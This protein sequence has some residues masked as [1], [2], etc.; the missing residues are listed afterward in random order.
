[1]QHFQTGEKFPSLILFPAGIVRES[2]STNSVGAACPITVAF[3]TAGNF[4]VANS[5]SNNILSTIF[6][7]SISG[8]N[9]IEKYSANFTDLGAFATNLNQPWG[10]AF[11][12]SGNLFV[13][14]SGTNGTYRSSIL[15]IAPDGSITTFANPNASLKQPCGI[16]FDSAGN[17]FVACAGFWKDSE[18]SS[19]RRLFRFCDRLERTDEP[20]DLSR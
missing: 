6:P 19:H 14:N 4:F 1:M 2:Y 3:D 20:G 9:T 18:I 15:K 16:A 13:S 12:A 8:D 5:W 17:L 7:A 10:L 11:D